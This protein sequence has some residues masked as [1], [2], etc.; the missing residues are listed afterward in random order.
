MST[1]N[2]Q[3]EQASVEAVTEA[4]AQE[5]VKVG[6]QQSK[7]KERNRKAMSKARQN[8][9]VDGDYTPRQTGSLRRAREERIIAAEEAKKARAEKNAAEENRAVNDVAWFLGLSLMVLILLAAASLL[10]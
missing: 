1:A 7:N 6:A 2:G 8:S 5:E 3:R 4:L 10:I 9:S